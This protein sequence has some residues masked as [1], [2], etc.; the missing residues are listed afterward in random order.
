MIDST[1]LQFSVLQRRSRG[2]LKYHIN[3]IFTEYKMKSL[4]LAI[5][6]DLLN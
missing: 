5:S 3:C 6:L 1:L 4:L 2:K